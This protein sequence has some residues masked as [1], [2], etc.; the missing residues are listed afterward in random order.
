MT[1]K[2]FYKPIAPSVDSKEID[3]DINDKK[4]VQF[5]YGSNDVKFTENVLIQFN[6]SLLKCDNYSTNDGLR[7]LKKMFNFLIIA[8][9]DEIQKSTKKINEDH[10]DKIEI[11]EKQ[12]KKREAIMFLEKEFGLITIPKVEEV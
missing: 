9:D 11:I 7:M 12:I 5:E 3:I 4:F 6:H 8:R 10:K 1:E 2:N